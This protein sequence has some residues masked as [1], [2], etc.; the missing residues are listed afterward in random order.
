MCYGKLVLW[1]ST[2]IEHEWNMNLIALVQFSCPIVTV[3]MAEYG[4][5]ISSQQ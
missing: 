1:I 4:K 2:C 5:V 3:T